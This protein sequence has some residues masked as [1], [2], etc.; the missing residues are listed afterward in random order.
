VSPAT[1]ALHG[2]DHLIYTVPFVAYG[3]FR[4]IFEVQEGRHDSPV[5]VLLKDPAFTINGILWILA[6]LVILRIYGKSPVL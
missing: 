6:A 5:E 2:T 3:I 4:Y 1:I